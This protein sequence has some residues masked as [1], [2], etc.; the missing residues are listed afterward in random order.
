MQAAAR[1]VIIHHLSALQ[2]PGLGHRSARLAERRRWGRTH[3]PRVALGSRVDS[4]EPLSGIQLENFFGSVSEPEEL[5]TLPIKRRIDRRWLR[6]GGHS[7]KGLEQNA[8]TADMMQKQ[9]LVYARL[10]TPGSLYESCVV[11]VVPPILR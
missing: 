4:P 9:P 6:C 1:G 5:P 2:P 7:A 8:S 3:S 11:N 10:C